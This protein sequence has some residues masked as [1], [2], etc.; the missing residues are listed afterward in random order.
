VAIPG[1]SRQISASRPDQQA[2]LIL[3]MPANSSGVREHNGKTYVVLENAN[4]VLAV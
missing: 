1:R 3:D 4:G 2:G